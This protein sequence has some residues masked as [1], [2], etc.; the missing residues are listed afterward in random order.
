LELPAQAG[1]NRI[2]FLFFGFVA[3]PAFRLA[4]AMLKKLSQDI[5]ILLNINYL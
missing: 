1:L 3:E 2:A 5:I 4:P